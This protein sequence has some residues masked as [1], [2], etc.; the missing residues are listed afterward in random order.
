MATIE[1]PDKEFNRL[2]LATLRV[3]DMLS[4]AEYGCFTWWDAF[5]R[6]VRENQAALMELGATPE[7]CGLV[8]VNERG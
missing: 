4:K 8:E 6:A 5:V 7:G 2:F 1:D 3:S